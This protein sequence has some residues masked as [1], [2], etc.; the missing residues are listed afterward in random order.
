MQI[1]QDDLRELLRRAF[2]LGLFVQHS[3]TGTKWTEPEI[4]QKEKSVVDFILTEYKGG[5]K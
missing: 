5:K 4:K 2:N 3:H 1:R